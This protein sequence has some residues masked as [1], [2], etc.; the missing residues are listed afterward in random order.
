M[1]RR[2]MTLIEMLVAMTATLILMGAIARVF[3]VFGTAITNSRAVLATDAQ[4]RTAAWRLRS[5]LSGI[6]CRTLPPRGPDAGEGYFELIEGPAKPARSPAAATRRITTDGSAVV[7]TSISETG[8][9][10]SALRTAP[11]TTTMCSFSPRA[12]PTHRL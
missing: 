2:G 1:N 10:R 6:T 3:S 5:D 8:R 4:L 7:V 9:P 12:Q 11:P